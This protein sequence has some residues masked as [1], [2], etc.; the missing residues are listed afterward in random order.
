MI[1]KKEYFISFIIPVYNTAPELLERCIKSVQ[2][3]KQQNI[4]L[5]IINDGS[6]NKET[7]NVL[8]KYENKKNIS[9]YHIKN[10][11][12]SSARNLG[13]DVATGTYI[14]FLDSDDYISEE[15][16]YQV[17]KIMAENEELYD[18]CCFQNE[19]I[20][21]LNIKE[22]KKEHYE[23]SFFNS[24]YQASNGKDSNGNS[25]KINDGTVWA[26][27]YRKSIL[28]NTRFNTE[29]KYCEDTL[30]NIQLDNLEKPR[31]LAINIPVYM[32]MENPD[33]LCQKY[34]PSAYDDFKKA[35]EIVYCQLSEHSD[36]NRIDEFNITVL[37][38]FYMNHIL[39]LQVFNKENKDGF[40]K[41]YFCALKMLHSDTFFKSFKQ[42]DIKKCSLREKMV[43]FLLKCGL[44]WPAYKLY[45]YRRKED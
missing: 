16:F 27:I 6:L 26:K 18:I 9:V 30:F 34:N 41:K 43:Y 3:L 44:I 14:S 31:V 38:H 1:E 40:L 10:C 35:T 24:L 8:Y 21:E 13:L 15:N 17:L 19:I 29:L 20:R 42:I 28:N 12:A 4:E 7:L 33:S 32:Y 5:V 39:N 25:F 2:K 45:F 22:E 37:F 11:G 36:K 23:I